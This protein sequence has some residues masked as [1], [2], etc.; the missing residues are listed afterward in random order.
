[1]IG[2]YTDEDFFRELTTDE[3]RDY[4]ISITS[5]MT[6][7]EIKEL[8]IKVN[9]VRASIVERQLEEKNMDKRLPINHFF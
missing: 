8:I 5:A 4:L 9:N 7:K 6:N 3:Q 1:M 2:D